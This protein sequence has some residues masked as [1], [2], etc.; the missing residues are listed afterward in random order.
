MDWTNWQDIGLLVLLIAFFVVAVVF[1][2]RRNNSAPMVVAMNL[3]RDID[4]NQK[5]INSFSYQAKAKNFRVK[6]WQ[7]NRTR[8]DFLNEDLRSD[9]N[10]GF[11]M[12]EEFNQQIDMARKTGS[13]TYPVSIQVD[14]LKEPLTRAREGLI[15]WIQDNWGNR[16]Y[17]PKRIGFFN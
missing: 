8:M 1:N 4:K 14:K 5:M 9:I 11:R 13:A 6:N 15:K 12:A 10:A 7:K 17:L 3:Y 16:A 2:K